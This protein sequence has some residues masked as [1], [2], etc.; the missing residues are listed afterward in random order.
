MLSESRKSKTLLGLMYWKLMA[1]SP[2]ARATSAA[3][4]AWASSFIRVEET[5]S[6][7]AASMSWRMASR[8]NPNACWESQAQSATVNRARI[9]IE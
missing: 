9:T 4:M 1:N 7:S 2:P 8:A 5:P 6:A 3:E